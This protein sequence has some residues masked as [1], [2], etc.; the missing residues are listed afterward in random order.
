MNA[1]T[2]VVKKASQ[3]HPIGNKISTHFKKTLSRPLTY[4]LISTVNVST[5]S[6]VKHMTSRGTSALTCTILTYVN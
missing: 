5:W 1:I 3:K 6:H 2:S 4:L